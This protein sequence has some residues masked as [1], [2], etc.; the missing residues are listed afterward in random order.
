MGIILFIVMMMAY[1][2]MMYGHGISFSTGFKYRFVYIISNIFWALGFSCSIIDLCVN[3]IDLSGTE[4][5]DVLSSVIIVLL[6]LGSAF[7]MGWITGKRI[8]RCEVMR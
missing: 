5:I 4:F 8:E 3:G 2:L 1:W 6:W 7:L